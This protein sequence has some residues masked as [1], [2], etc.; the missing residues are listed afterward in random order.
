MDA[1]HWSKR[2]T[3]LLAALLHA[4]AVD[5]RDVGVVADWVLRHELDEPGIVLEKA[6][7]H[8]ACGVL[9]GLQNTEA[10]ERSSICSAAADALDAYSSHSALAAATDSNFDADQFVASRDTVYVHAPA[11]HQALA[12]PLV[13]GLLADIRRATYQAH[14]AGRLPGRVLWAL[15]EVANIAPLTEL[16]AIASEGRGQGLALLAALQDL[17]QAR[18]RWG[19]AADGFL[20]PFGSKLILPGVADA[21]T[22]ETVSVALGEYDRQV[23]ATTG[24]VVA[25]PVRT[26]SAGSFPRSPRQ[27]RPSA[28]GSS[29]PARSQTSP[30][31]MPC[32]STAC[33]GSC[34]G[35]R[36]P[37]ATSHGARWPGRTARCSHDAPAERSGGR[38]RA[39]DGRARGRLGTFQGEHRRCVHVCLGLGT[40]DGTE[41]PT[42]KRSC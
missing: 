36:P 24:G 42:G 40:F 15:D 31:G 3:A 4:A 18:A 41:R 22:L 11:E 5:H 21:K 1:T 25:A 13:C 14:H 8:L 29:R 17:S 32:I 35:S 33:A 16:P 9:V 6:Q 20:T 37:I 19:P 28:S 27:S 39:R 10:R 26:C 38:D 34:S 30:R 12:A 2:A 7:A 23:V